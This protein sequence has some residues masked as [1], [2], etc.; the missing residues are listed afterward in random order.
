MMAFKHPVSLGDGHLGA[1]RM[2]RERR[3]DVVR[4]MST[5]LATLSVGS[6][7]VEQTATT[8]RR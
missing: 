4:P 8:L 5:D 7:I 1:R 6:M 2:R 3:F